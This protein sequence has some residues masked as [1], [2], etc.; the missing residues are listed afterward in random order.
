MIEKS[1]LRLLTLISTS[2]I[3]LIFFGLVC[4]FVGQY[5]KVYLMKFSLFEVLREVFYFQEVVYE[6]R[7][8]LFEKQTFMPHLIFLL[9]ALPF[10]INWPH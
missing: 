7:H 2:P 5:R 1:F 8:I 10:G 6:H 3:I 4:L 9:I